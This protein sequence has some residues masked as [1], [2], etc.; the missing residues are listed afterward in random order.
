MAQYLL[1]FPAKQAAKEQAE[2]ACQKADVSQ[3]DIQLF[4]GLCLYIE[5]V[6]HISFPQPVSNVAGT[7]PK[8]QGQSQLGETADAVGKQQRDAQNGNGSEDGCGKYFR[9]YGIFV[10]SIECQSMVVDTINLEPPS[11]IFAGKSVKHSGYFGVSMVD[12]SF[13]PQICGTDK[14]T[15]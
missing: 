1:F 10:Q 3:V 9:Q 5:I 11:C 6:H 13:A 12:F 7:S 4:D 2:K 15:D 8:H 14:S